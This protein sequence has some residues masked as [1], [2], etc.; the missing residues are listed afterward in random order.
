MT[1]WAAK[2]TNYPHWAHGSI[3]HRRRETALVSIASAS[4]RL[5]ATGKSHA[6]CSYDGT[7]AFASSEKEDLQEVSRQLVQE[8]HSHQLADRLDLQHCTMHI[9]KKEVTFKNEEGDLMGHTCTADIC[10][11]LIAAS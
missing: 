3:K 5:N 6:F 10:E 4:W 8:R 7:N 1:N 9:D 11:E 2:D